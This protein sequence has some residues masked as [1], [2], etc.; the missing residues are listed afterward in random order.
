M[1]R[2]SFKSSQGSFVILT[3]VN[4]RT[5][6][7]SS[8]KVRPRVTYDSDYNIREIRYPNVPVFQKGSQLSLGRHPFKVD[9]IENTSDKEIFELKASPLSTSSFFLLPALGE[10]REEFLWA[11]NYVNCFT[12]VE[13]PKIKIDGPYLYLLYRFSGK[14][15]YTDFEERLKYHP[16]Y[17]GTIDVD[18]YHVMY[19][20]NF[21]SDL[22][23]QYLLFKRG[24]Y[25]HMDEAYKNQVLDFHHAS[26][27]SDLKKIL[28]RDP[29]KR[30]ALEESFNVDKSD[31]RKVKISPDAELYDPPNEHKE[32]YFNRYKLTTSIMKNVEFDKE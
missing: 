27:T 17:R 31:R 29:K 8:A 30:I 19:V 16:E 23:E 12:N 21:P 3:P 14:K 20:F 28:D 10:R 22:I 11:N 1:Q 25:S 4:A 13:D 7:L 32:T 18:K 24:K 2:T 26:N 5:V 15:F 9:I 6:R